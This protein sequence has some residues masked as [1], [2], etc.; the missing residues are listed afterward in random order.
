MTPRGRHAPGT[1][2]MPLIAMPPAGTAAVTGTAHAG[3][4]VLVTVLALGGLAFSLL[5]SMVAPALPPISHDLHAPPASA[6]WIV[7]SY[8]V[9]AAV[10]TP[11]AGRMGDL[12]GRRPVLIAVLGVLAVGCAV[13]ALAHTLT[14]LVIGRAVQGTAGAVFPLAFGILRDGLPAQRVSTAV[15][16]L[17]AMLGVGGGF[18]IVLAGP[19][20]IHLGWHWIFWLPLGVTAIALAA[21]I[22][23]VPRTARRDPGGLSLPS[24]LLLTAWLVAALLPV[25]NGAVWGWTSPLT[26]ALFGAAVV[27]A[28]AWVMV[29]VRSRSPLVDLRL[30][31]ERPVWAADL[32]ALAFGFGMFGSFLLVPALLEAPARTGYGFGQSVS[33]AGLFL[34]PGSVMLLAFGPV[35]GIMTRRLGPRAPIVAGSAVCCASFALPAVV[36]AHIWQVL[37]CATGSGIGLGLAYAA[38]PNAIIAHVPAQQTGVATGVNTLARS[39]GSSIGAAVVAAIL[40]ARIVPGG[41][42]WAAG[43]T[44]GFGACAVMF[45]VGGAA[46]LLIR[47]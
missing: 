41:F 38:L 11:I 9:A 26:L 27:I 16:L 2:E 45:G 29:E 23:V 10:A 12:W 21:A 47:P 18:G 34:L 5:Q 22:A 25:S 20:V 40:A 15:G 35:S 24:A 28:M 3:S 13:A 14:V 36:H 19:I 33:G 1:S 44:I 42:P 37:A 43:F 17:S 39:I 4:A 46:A 7:T 8:L 6:G 32:S 31:L 30:L